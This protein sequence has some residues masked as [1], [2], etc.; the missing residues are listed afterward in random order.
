ML[1]YKNTICCSKCGYSELNSALE[2]HHVDPNTKLMII[3]K[4][5]GSSSK[6]TDEIKHEL[7]K[8]IILCANCHREE[9]YDLEFFEINK[10]YILNKSRNIK[11]LQPKLDKQEVLRLYE[12]GMKQIDIA[13]KYK[14]SKGTINGILRCFGKTTPK[15]DK[16]INRSIVFTLFQQGKTSAEISRMLNVSGSSISNIKK[17]LGLR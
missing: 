11:E 3:S 15:E 1:E 4:Y 16:I 12:S 2:F 6:L 17:E 9:H 8:C 10:D 7:D 14:A 13:R 5:R